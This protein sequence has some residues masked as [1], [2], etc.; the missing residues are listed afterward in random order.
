MLTTTSIV[1]TRFYTRTELYELGPSSRNPEFHKGN[2]CTN[3]YHLLMESPNQSQYNCKAGRDWRED[4]DPDV[5]CSTSVMSAPLSYSTHPYN[6][7][8][9]M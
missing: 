2:G 8:A 4:G 6:E 7:T 5:P 1:N 3:V 9:K